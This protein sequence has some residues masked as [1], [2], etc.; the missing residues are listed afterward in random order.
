M[1]C[2]MAFSSVVVNCSVDRRSRLASDVRYRAAVKPFVHKSWKE[3]ERTKNPASARSKAVY[4]NESL[5]SQMKR[6]LIF[7]SI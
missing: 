1:N 6:D 3:L 5:T 2:D 4:E 7:Y